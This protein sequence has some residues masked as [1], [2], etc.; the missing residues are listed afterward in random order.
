ML[1]SS[2]F[3]EFQVYPLL[4]GLQSSGQRLLMLPESAGAALPVPGVTAANA[5]ITNVSFWPRRVVPLSPV[6]ADL[7]CHTVFLTDVSA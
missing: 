2:F 4:L 3:W 7:Y 6:S 5:V 1:A